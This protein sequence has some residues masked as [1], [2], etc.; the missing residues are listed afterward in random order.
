MHCAVYSI[1]LFVF[2][3]QLS[4]PTPCTN[5]D[6]SMLLHMKYSKSSAELK[7]FKSIVVTKKFLLTCL[8]I[9][10]PLILEKANKVCVF[11]ISRIE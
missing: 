4:L 11:I 8:D 7:S 1:V 5:D 2:C 6:V 10:S 3:P 9:F